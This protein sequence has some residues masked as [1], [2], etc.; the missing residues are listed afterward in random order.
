L[1]S[2]LVDRL[3][4]LVLAPLLAPVV[5]VLGWRVRRHDGGPPLIGLDRIGR[6][7][8]TFSMWKLRSMRADGPGGTAGGST[9]TA[10]GD[11]RITPIGATMRRWRLDELPQVWNVLR[12]D[13]AVL[14]PR[15]ET[16]SMVD[17]DDPRWRAVL[18]AKP[19]ITGPTQLLVERW[20]AET[21]AQGSAADDYRDVVLPVKL[22]VDRWYVERGTPVTDVQVVCSMLQR[23]VLGRDQTWVERAVRREVPEA[24]RVPVGGR[25]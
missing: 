9:I 7:G 24:A 1:R 17:L 12:G 3:V 11:D 18:A 2:L 10:T 5:A 14:G 8:R 16:P 23:F 22:A 21:L 13:M 15:P 25:A 6:D 19:G 4:A 20:E